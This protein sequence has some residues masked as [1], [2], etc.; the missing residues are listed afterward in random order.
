M[1]TN[2]REVTWKDMHILRV[3]GVWFLKHENYVASFKHA[4]RHIICTRSLWNIRNWAWGN[5]EFKNHGIWNQTWLHRSNFNSLA[6][7]RHLY[8]AGEKTRQ[9]VLPHKSCSFQLTSYRLWLIF[10]KHAR[11]AIEE[12]FKQNIEIC[13]CL[14]YYCFIG[15]T[16]NQS[17]DPG[18]FSKIS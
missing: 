12:S 6:V 14:R 10:Y 11:L 15:L 13:C 9:R 4:L 17:W 3:T 5:P 8:L 1:H 18:L 16:R 2:F 7:S